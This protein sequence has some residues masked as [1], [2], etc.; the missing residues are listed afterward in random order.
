MKP[1]K[2]LV[3]LF[4]TALTCLCGCTAGQGSAPA[5]PLSP[6]P[7]SPKPLFNCTQ[8]PPGLSL[9]VI[10][11]T[12][13]P[14]PADTPP[15]PPAYLHRIRVEG[16]GF[17]PGENVNIAVEGRAET[18]RSGGGQGGGVHVNA[19]GSFAWGPIGLA[20]DSKVQWQ[21]YVVHQRGVACASLTT[22]R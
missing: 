21:V 7:I 1:K 9:R 12:G 2:L 15:P 16:Q 3:L 10:E 5:A 14:D 13:T 19:D 6:P 22:G 20:A 8:D 4:A 11:V 18:E 17:T